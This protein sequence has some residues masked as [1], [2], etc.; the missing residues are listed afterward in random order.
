MTK[1]SI[2]NDKKLGDIIIIEDVSNKYFLAYR[3]NEPKI[4]IKEQTIEKVIEELRRIYKRMHEI[5]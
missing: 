5:E 2:I 1:V 4:K 3:K